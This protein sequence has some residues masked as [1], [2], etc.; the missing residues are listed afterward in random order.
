MNFTHVLR[1][2]ATPTQDASFSKEDGTV[3]AHYRYSS[4]PTTDSGGAERPLGLNSSYYTTG[5]SLVLLPSYTLDNGTDEIA[6]E[7]VVGLDESGF[8]GVKDWALQ[9]LVL[10]IT[11]A[12]IV[13]ALVAG[14]VYYV[15][16]RRK[17]SE[18][19]KGTGGGVIRDDAPDRK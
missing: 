1:Q 11:T 6:H 10:L 13:A 8:V 12:G 9:N 15:R 16:R 3:Q 2:T 17:S 7:M 4:E 14:S 18:G 5:T 19:M